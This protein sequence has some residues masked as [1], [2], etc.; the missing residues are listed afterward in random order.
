MYVNEDISEE[1]VSNFANEHGLLF[2]AVSAKKNLAI[3]EL[4]K[5]VTAL[6]LKGPSAHDSTNKTIN[7]KSDELKQQQNVKK[8]CC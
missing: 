3:N 1:V 4:F 8:A 5:E 7:L 6:Y 2:K